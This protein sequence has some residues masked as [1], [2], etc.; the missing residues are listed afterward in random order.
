MQANTS[1]CTIA[2]AL[3][4]YITMQLFD[5][6]EQVYHTTYLDSSIRI[7]WVAG[8]KAGT[9]GARLIFVRAQSEIQ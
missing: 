4:C 6:S 5:P 1:T 2:F 3:R 7:V 9:A 8:G